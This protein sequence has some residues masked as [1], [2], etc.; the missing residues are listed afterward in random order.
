[1]MA[2][3]RAPENTERLPDTATSLPLLGLLG[4]CLLAT[5][6]LSRKSRTN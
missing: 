4:L 1:M 6:L 5:G 2:S 3:A